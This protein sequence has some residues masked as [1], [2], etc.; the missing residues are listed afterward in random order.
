LVKESQD[1]A[2]TAERKD[3]IEEQLKELTRRIEDNKSKA[4]KALNKRQG[5]NSR[6]ATRTWRRSGGTT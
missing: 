6:N 5:S 2:T 1:P 3:Q 4:S